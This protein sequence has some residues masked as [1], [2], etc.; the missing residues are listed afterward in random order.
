M[1]ASLLVTVLQ[2]YCQLCHTVS[3]G[4]LNSA[5]SLTHCASVRILQIGQYLIKLLNFVAYCLDL[6]VHCVCMVTASGHYV[7]VIVCCSVV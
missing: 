6:L 5:H 1:M 2:I 3:G 4:A 7:F